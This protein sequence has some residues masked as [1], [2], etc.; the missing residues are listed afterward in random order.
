VIRRNLAIVEGDLYSSSKLRKSYMDLNRLR[1]FEEI[2]FQTE[3]GPDETLTDINIQVKEK[4]TGIFSIGAG[5]SALDKAIFTAS[6]SQQNLF[7]RGQTLALKAN[8]GSRTTMYELSFIEPWLFDIPLW[9]KFDAHHFT[10]EY[11]TYDLDSDGLGATFG[12][13][14]WEYI[15]G[16][17]GYRITTNNVKNIKSNASKYV[18][19]QKGQTTTSMMSATLARDTTDDYIFPSKGSKNTI[20]VDYAGGFLQGDSSFTRYG[21]SSSWFFPL[22]LETVFGVRGRIGYLEGREGKKVPVY[23]R[24]YLGGMHSLRGL[25]SVGP[26]DPETGDVIGGLTM[27][28]FNG[29]FIFNLIKNAGMKGVIFYDTGNAWESGYHLNDM[30]RTAGLG[31][32]WYSPIGPLRLE[33]GYVLDRKDDEPAS[34]WEFTIGMLM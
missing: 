20:T 23:E 15:M 14:I 7:G 27:L 28:N 32:R 9:S 10:R 4:P 11:D 3:K 2:N 6:I 19:E 16:Y 21:A 24:F 8:L 17:V 13:P 12:Y 29:E 1:Y 34:R 26:K 30:R 5:Y 22:P 25:R 18:I 33:W 31:I